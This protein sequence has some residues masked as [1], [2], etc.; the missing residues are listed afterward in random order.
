[1]HDSFADARL[2]FPTVHLS[3]PI[4]SSRLTRLALLLPLVAAATACEIVAPPL[5]DDAVG[6]TPPPVY[7]RWWRMV[8]E[9]S[10]RRGSLD[11]VAWY[12][13]P[14]ASSVDVNGEPASGYWSRG[15]NQIVLAGP[16][17][18]RGDVVRHEMLHALV[19]GRGHP[20]E[21]FLGAC[22][23]VV[24]C[25]GPCVE[26]TFVAPG[27]ATAVTANAL[28]LD[29]E[30][31]PKP[32]S[33]LVDGGSFSVIVTARNPR[34]TAVRV[35]SFDGSTRNVR[36]WGF[37]IASRVHGSMGQHRVVVDG[38][39]LW[40]APGE[41]KRSVFDLHVIQFPAGDYTVSGAFDR[42]LSR[43]VAVAIER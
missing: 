29:V 27:P 18:L 7:S 33:G 6:F 25:E 2:V 1:V 41:T 5:P 31:V 38:S 11:A 20:R 19:R 36:T 35:T 22:A 16:Y 10:G 15:G 37:E 8:E 17:T 4:P 3:R 24:H 13:V 43:G 12:E 40:F 28:E 9:C 23:G 14:G 39:T 21:Q 42:S 34:A 32:P 30:V 26:G